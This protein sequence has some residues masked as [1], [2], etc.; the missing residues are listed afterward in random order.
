MFVYKMSILDLPC[1]I[2]G[3][4]ALH[5]NP[6]D[7]RSL[8]R[9]SRRIAKIIRETHETYVLYN[10]VRCRDERRA[11]TSYMFFGMLH[12]GGDLPA[13]IQ[14]DGVRSWYRFG[15]LHR[16]GGP[17]R[18]WADGSEMWYVDG[19]LH[20]DGDLPAAVYIG[21]SKR[22]YKNGEQHRDG[23]LPACV[24]IDGRVEFWIMGKIVR[25]N[26]VVAWG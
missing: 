9:T 20:R 1:D 4:I 10:T 25:E 5:T 18:T 11:T 23:G 13:V 14:D 15:R 26:S 24:R 22:W 17:A 7:R 8:A 21:D 6:R 2:I 12:R 19:K 16:I 3:L